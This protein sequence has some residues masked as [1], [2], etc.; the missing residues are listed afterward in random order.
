MRLPWGWHAL[1]SNEIYCRQ[2]RFQDLNVLKRVLKSQ[3]IRGKVRLPVT[4]T[5]VNIEG[6]FAEGFASTGYAARF[7]AMSFGAAEVIG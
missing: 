1:T 4:T 5:G 2:R 6:D 7:N 3:H